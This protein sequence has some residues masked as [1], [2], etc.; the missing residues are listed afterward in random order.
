MISIRRRFVLISLLTVTLSLAAASAVLIQIFA[1]SYSRRVQNEL[2]SHISRLAAA[3]QFGPDGRLLVPA[4]PAD[5]R[6]LIPYSGLYWQIDDPTG[7]SELRSPSLFDHALPLPDDAHSP[8]TIHTYRLE[9]PEHR[10]VMVQERVVV[11]A[12][13]EGTRPIRISVA[14]DA[15]EI[16]AARWT[17]ALAILPYIMALALFLVVMSLVQLAFGLK[18]LGR[19]SADLHLI[20]DRRADR[21]PGPYPKELRGLADQLNHLLEIQSA[22]IDKARARASD[23]AHGLKTPLTILSNNA[24]TLREKGQTA[25]ADELDQLANAMLAHVDHELARARITPT[26]EQRRDDAH[27]AKIITD[28]IRALKRSGAGEKLAWHTDIPETLRL[29]IDPH[30]FHELVGNLLENATKWARKAIWVRMEKDDADWR[31]VVEDDGPGVPEDRLPE[32][33]RRG[34]RLDHLKP[35][36]GLGLAIV[37]E[38][39]EVYGL[40][41]TL[42]N[43]VEGGFRAEILFTS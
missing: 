17:F 23:L 25:M 14:I 15:T 28:V 8:G 31:L 24:F 5:N 38:I 29:P 19:M 2:T 21:L 10:D 3:L 16:D 4:S 7:K 18:P 33:T 12:A 13:P 37:S 22:A 26:P 34:M 40:S 27:A 39:A 35:G 42:G 11:V 9:G 30:D 36:T 20:R 43:R 41:V 6:F 1:D 32:L